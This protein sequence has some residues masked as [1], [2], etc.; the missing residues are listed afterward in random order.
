MAKWL[1]IGAGVV[2]LSIG[3]A[4]YVLNSGAP[5]PPQGVCP[6]LLSAA[7]F[8][9]NIVAYAD[10]TSMR[11]ADLTKQFKTFEQTPQAAAYRDFVANTNFHI[12][13]DLDHILLAASTEGQNG[14]LVLEGRFDQPRVSTYVASL[15]GTM[16]HYDAGDLYE[17]QVKSAPAT[18]SMM[19]LG[20]SRL[21]F[22]LGRDAHTEMLMLA[23][24]AKEA[25]PNL[26]ADI[27]ARVERVA[28]APFFL[29]GDVPKAAV[30]Q[31]TPVV[32]RENPSA[33]DILQSLRGWDMAYWMDGDSVR[34]AV[35]G[36]FENSYDALKSRLAFENVRESI[37][38]AAGQSKTGPGAASPAAPIVDAMVKNLAI[39][40]DGRYVRMGTALKKSDLQALATSA[41][42]GRH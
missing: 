24:A 23:D 34:M 36:Q 11:S 18:T 10:L 7:P 21:A 16:K 32:A 31:I 40:I 3:T 6:A 29:L 27:C 42:A 12:D 15:G 41:T 28:G 14:A 8:D 13:R 1:W 26:H 22:A 38:K 2:L 35:E 17:F 39:S 9:A 4:G 5:A 20:P 19:F 33:A 37:Q 30:A 25:D